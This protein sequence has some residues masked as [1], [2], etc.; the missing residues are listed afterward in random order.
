MHLYLRFSCRALG[1]SVSAPGEPLGTTGETSAVLETEE[2][3]VWRQPQS[4]QAGHSVRGL[5]LSHDSASCCHCAGFG[6]VIEQQSLR[7]LL[8]RVDSN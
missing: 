6:V 5:I 7:N 4:L 1:L 8:P 2:I 3:L